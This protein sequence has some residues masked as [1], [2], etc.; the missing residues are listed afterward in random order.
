MLRE[1]EWNYRDQ[2]VLQSDALQNALA[3]AGAIRTLG[4]DKELQRT[5]GANAA[6]RVRD[7]F[8]PE[9]FKERLLS[10]LKTL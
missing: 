6:A 8:M 4:E 9:Q 2:R 3:L 1:P 10:L 7:N 5:L